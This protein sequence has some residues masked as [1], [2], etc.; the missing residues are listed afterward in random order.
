LVSVTL[1][2]SSYAPLFS[3]C[4]LI[5]RLDVLPRV[6]GLSSLEG[7]NIECILFYFVILLI[8]V[9]IIISVIVFVIIGIVFIILFLLS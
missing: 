2:N 6:G 9:M 7:M 4:I 5:L 8:I 1:S 3:L